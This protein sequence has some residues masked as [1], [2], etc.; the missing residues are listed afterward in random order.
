MLA[1]ESNLFGISPF[2]PCQPQARRLTSMIQCG[3]A[4]EIY[5]QQ[6]Y[7]NKTS[8]RTRYILLTVLLKSLIYLSFRLQI[9]S[10]HFHTEFSF[11]EVTSTLG[12][13]V[14][15]FLV[16]RSFQ[17]TLSYILKDCITTTPSPCQIVSSGSHDTSWLHSKVESSDS[18]PC[19]RN[20][21]NT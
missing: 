1:Q 3:Y 11:P 20:D 13:P 6:I 9:Q 15:C 19:Q 17:A 5:R 21:R 18:R 12:F 8:I 10:I 2:I 16:T 7:S 4:S 14:T